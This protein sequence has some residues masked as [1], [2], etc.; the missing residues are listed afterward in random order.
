MENKILDGLDEEIKR[1]QERMGKVEPASQ[2]YDYLVDQLDKLH[3]LRMTEVKHDDDVSENA[4]KVERELMK[5]SDEAER[6]EQEAIERAKDRRF[7]KV[8]RAVEVG[9][10]VVFYGALAYFG[11]KFEESGSISSFTF[12]NFLGKMKPGKK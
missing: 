2:E 7:D 12:R 11:F 3:K 10:P 6:Q 8:M 1:I 5:D 9:V 4:A